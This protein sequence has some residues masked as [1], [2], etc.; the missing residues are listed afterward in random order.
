MAVVKRLFP[1]DT[2]EEMSSSHLVLVRH[3]QSLWNKKNLFTGWQDV[4]LSET[5]IRQARETGAFLKG[6]GLHFDCAYT[7]FL[8]RAI[9]TLWLLLEEM[10]LMWI[11]VV[12]SWKLNERHYGALQG[13]DKKEAIEKF[14]EDQVM[15]WRRSF[16]SAPP[17]APQE[18]INS[19]SAYASISIPGS[20]SLKVTQARV[21]SFW[22]GDILPQIQQGRSVLISAH[23]NS[24]RAL[25]KYLE[26]I[27]DE[28][29]FHLNIKTGQ[30]VI[31]QM[32]S[33]GRV[34]CRL[35]L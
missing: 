22:K 18:K 3:G 31:Y 24:L 30:P 29:I 16:L 8:K 32:N 23:G 15:Q 21:L 26:D 9:H 2:G 19:L 34:D 25:I 12:K 10:D 17:E 13:V 11:P 28:D 1:R 27:S 20:E 4:G 7:S 6:K 14:G 33:Q 35:S 5:G